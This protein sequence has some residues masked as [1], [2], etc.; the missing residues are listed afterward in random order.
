M[1]RSIE[2]IP[3]VGLLVETARGYGRDMLRGIMKYEQEHGPWCFHLT[4]GDFKQALPQMSRWHGTGI[5]ARTDDDL[6][7]EQA[8]LSAKIPTVLLD[9]SERQLAPKHPFS[10]LAEIHPDSESIGQLAADYFINRHFIQFGFVGILDRIW[11]DKRRQG[12]MTSVQNYGYN[13]RYFHFDIQTAY[14]PSDSHLTINQTLD[15]Q[16]VQLVD[17]LRKMPKPIA[18]MACDDVI[19]RYVIDACRIANISV[20]QEVAVL[21]VDDDH[22]FCNLSHPSLSSIAVNA[23][24]GGYEAAA[25]LDRMMKD[26]KQSSERIIVAPMDIKSRQSTDVLAIDDQLIKQAMQIINEKAMLFITIDDIAQQCHVSRRH[27][28]IRFR[29]VLNRSILDMLQDRKIRYACERLQNT[30]SP[31]EQIAENTGYCSVSYFIQVF[32]NYMHT[33]PAGYRRKFSADLY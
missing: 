13:A 32:R 22:F 10:K 33:T 16:Q 3:R 29:K 8:I 7:F 21:G 4:P 2:S 20:P 9:M 28:E 31:I 23:M 6:E 25:L 1:N 12:F 5:I 26:E 19:G 27:L 11:S 30:D 18:I 17:W 14:A 24:K 15:D